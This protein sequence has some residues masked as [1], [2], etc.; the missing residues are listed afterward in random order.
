MKEVAFFFGAN[1]YD[2]YF[3]YT[4]VCLLKIDTSFYHITDWLDDVD[5]DVGCSGLGVSFDSLRWIPLL[6]RQCIIP[7]FDPRP[8]V[9][10]SHLLLTALS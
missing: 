9:S 1:R 3:Q 7:M 2:T 6:S 10:A 5:I 8:K 4:T